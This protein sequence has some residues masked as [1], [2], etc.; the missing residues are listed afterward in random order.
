MSNSSILK[1]LKRILFCN[2]SLP[3]LPSCWVIA[4]HLKH[5]CVSNWIIPQFYG[6][7]KINNI[8]IYI[9]IYIYIY[10]IYY[11]HHWNHLATFTQT[12]FFEPMITL[13]E[14]NKITPAKSWETIL[15]RN[16]M[17]SL[18][19]RAFRSVSSREGKNPQSQVDHSINQGSGFP[20]QNLRQLGLSPQVMV[21]F[22]DQMLET[23]I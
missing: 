22:K 21:R 3:K 12:T 9:R 19:S 6:L 17:H 16:W 7:K 4:T 1:L 10:C 5:I 15:P 20:Q 13:P 23:N 18:F 2:S 11:I 14:T 8:Y